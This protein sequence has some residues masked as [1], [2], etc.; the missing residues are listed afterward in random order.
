MARGWREVPP[1]AG[2]PLAWRDFV[3]TGAS[4]ER[5]LADFLRQPAA[6]IECSGTAALVTAL[7]SLKRLS[8]RR[9]VVIPAYTCP[10]VALAVAHC[11][12]TP[13]A[14]DTRP[15]GFDLSPEA[16]AA[17]CGDDTLAVVVTHLGGRVADLATAAVIARSAGAYVI[18]DA[19]QSMG[20]AWRG[21]PVGG[22]GDIGVYSLGVGKGLTIYGGGVLVARDEA[23]RLEMRKT[24]AQIAPHRPGWELRR[25]FELAGYGLLYRPSGLKL[26][27]GLP[28]RRHLR[29]GRLIAAVGDDC[30]ADV[31]LHSVGA[32]RK[33]IGANALERLPAF[34]AAGT[35]RAVRRK[36]RLEAIG[37]IR[38]VADAADAAGIWPFLQVLMPTEQA[39]DAAL[40]GLWREGL[41]VGRLFIHALPDYPK[42]SPLFARSNVDNA[43]DF[44]ARML[45]V[46]NSEW[47]GEDRF[48]DICAGLERSVS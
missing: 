16:L 3:G 30:F 2:L 14:C 43:R 35:A 31:P 33:A 11:G 29:A 19:A 6:Q 39:R 1:T 10:L 23:L 7:A 17:A 13:V 25:L 38:V 36:A 22:I 20:A 34:L 40:G 28:L 24:A 9:S 32:W 12:L 18:E 5:S 26:A 8:G 27:Y 45:T 42:L 46:S 44:A 4:L 48:E 15:G 37:G 21:Q 41:G 47:L